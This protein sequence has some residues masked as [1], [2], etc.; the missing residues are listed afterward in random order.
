M[1]TTFKEREALAKRLKY[2]R[3]N[4]GLSRRDLDLSSGVSE[5]TI[6]DIENMR[7]SAGF[8]VL[9]KLARSFNMTLSEFLENI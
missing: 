5:T 3:T 2:L 4:K 1:N 7:V 9:V 6:K 8:D